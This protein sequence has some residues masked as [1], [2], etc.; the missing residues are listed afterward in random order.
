MSVPYGGTL[1]RMWE[2][3]AK[4][5]AM[6]DEA[7][8]NAPLRQAISDYVD[9]VHQAYLSQG[10]LQP[11]AVR[12]RMPLLAGP[13]TVVAAGVRNLDKPVGERRR[14]PAHAARRR[15]GS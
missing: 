10:Q 6:T 4:V 5:D 13:F 7:S 15:A 11:P 3:R 8:P 9:T 2:H 1:S 12:G 14:Y